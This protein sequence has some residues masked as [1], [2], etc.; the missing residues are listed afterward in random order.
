MRWAGILNKLLG[1]TGELVQGW[2]WFA[3]WRE[4]GVTL[5]LWPA[6]HRYA[7]S[8]CTWHVSQTGSC[9]CHSPS[10]TVSDVAGKQ[11]HLKRNLIKHVE[12]IKFRAKA[13]LFGNCVSK[14]VFN[15]PDQ[16]KSFQKL[17]FFF[18]R[19]ISLGHIITDLFVADSILAHRYQ[20]QLGSTS[21]PRSQGRSNSTYG[22]SM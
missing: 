10:S 21:L 3:L 20:A 6:Q 17:D 1:I 18:S 15:G 9:S 2:L 5:S 7:G 11:D 8:C 13:T 22:S 19:S 12:R 4:R 16:P 14:F